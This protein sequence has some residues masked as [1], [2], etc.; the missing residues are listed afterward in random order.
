MSTPDLEPRPPRDARHAWARLRRAGSPK[1][2]R[3]NIVAA[4]L[5]GALGFAIIAQVR[6]T[7]IEG[8][9]NLREDELIRVFADVD[10]D[11]EQLAGEISSLRASLELLQSRTTG[12]EEAQRAAQERLDSLEILAGTAV[13]EGPGITL[14]IRDPLGEVSAPTILDAVE[15]LRNAGAEAM[16]IGDV[17]IV[18]NTWFSDAD[19]GISVSGTVMSPPY[20]LLAIGD[21][22]TLAGAMEIPGGVT[23]TVRRAGGDAT[24]QIEDDVT[25][26]A[27]LPLQTPQYA[28]P[29]PTTDS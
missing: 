23:A 12:E 5:A 1:P 7:S 4:V 27:L 9:E 28:Q 20:V 18:A 14:T 29:V 15:E 25:V 22:N 16:Q 10:Q 6:Q 8:L 17:R 26:D 24:V 13:A 3:S 2:T 21:S 19:G 11:G